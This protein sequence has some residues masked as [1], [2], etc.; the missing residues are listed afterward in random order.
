MSRRTS[1]APQELEQAVMDDI[2]D[3]LTYEAISEKHGI[4]LATI[5]RIRQRVQRERLIRVVA[6]PDIHEPYQDE[7]SLAAVE[8]F[9]PRF[10]P[11]ILLYPG[12]QCDL[13]MIMDYWKKKPNKEAITENYDRFD[14]IMRRHIRLCPDAG[15]VFMEGNHEA[16]VHGVVS[17]YPMMAG[18]N[19]YIQDYL[20]FAERG[21]EFVPHGKLL[22]IG[23][24]NWMHGQYY[25]MH[26]AKK[27]VYQYYRNV[28]YG[29]TH[30]RQVH[31]QIN[32]ADIEDVHMAQSIGCLCNRNPHYRKNRPNRWVHGFEVTYID[33]DTGFFN[34]Y[35]IKITEGSFI[36]EGVKYPA[37][38]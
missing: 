32:P 13:Q 6:L 23:K 5:S 10:R 33:P 20:D 29:H 30:D 16:R 34:D 12:D 22:T 14:E 37:G 11:D 3:G 25:N 38:V 19:I 4:G 21:I 2:A 8:S 28:T 7:P 1:R 9:L 27:T 15:V 18:T 31:T 35:F 24:K 26:H 17:E 36:F